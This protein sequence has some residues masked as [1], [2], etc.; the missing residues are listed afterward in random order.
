MKTC[1]LENC[2]KKHEALG[3]CTKHYRRFKKHGDANIR[4]TLGNPVYHSLQEYFDLNTEKLG[5][6]CIV[7]TKALYKTGYGHLG[8]TIWSKK[9]KITLAHRL[10][11][12]HHKGEIPEGMLVLHKCDNR[13]C[14]N[15]DHLFLGTHSDNSHDMAMKGRSFQSQGERNPCA[16]LNEE[17]AIFIFNQH[18]LISANDLA[19]KFNVTP[20]TV[21]NIWHKRTKYIE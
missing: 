21:R 11:Y 17:E 19:K 1:K 13:K 20:S 4:L 12:F 6:G 15:I 18:G 3:Y 10:S 9:Y 2:D 16:K 7:W 14:V 8:R 5:N